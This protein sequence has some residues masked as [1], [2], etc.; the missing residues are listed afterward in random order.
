MIEWRNKS[1]DIVPAGSLASS[2]PGVSG[3]VNS[4]SGLGLLGSRRHVEEFWSGKNV[5]ADGEVLSDC[6]STLKYCVLSVFAT[7]IDVEDV[8]NASR[9]LIT[10][11]PKHAGRTFY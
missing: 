6:E 10:T 2:R 9:L 1:G 5:E 7:A 8:V 4:G 11:L 3:C